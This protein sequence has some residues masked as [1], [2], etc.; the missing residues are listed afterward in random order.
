MKIVVVA[1]ALVL[2]GSEFSPAVVARSCNAPGGC[3][4]EKR[5]YCGHRPGT[6][7]C[8]EG[9]W[10]PEPNGGNCKPFTRRNGRTVY[11]CKNS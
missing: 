9:V 1:L 6:T 3:F 8:V 5:V 10:L 2:A 7:K 11:F 4:G